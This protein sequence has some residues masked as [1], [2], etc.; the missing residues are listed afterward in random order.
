[1]QMS[2]SFHRLTVRLGDDEIIFQDDNSS[3][4]RIKDIKGFLFGRHIKSMTWSVKSSDIDEVE[5]L[6]RNFS[7]NG[8]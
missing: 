4:H 5:N 8:S 2:I 6:W 3:C 7:K 1:M